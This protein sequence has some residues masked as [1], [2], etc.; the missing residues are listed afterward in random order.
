MTISVPM[1]PMERQCR[2]KKEGSG[3]EHKKGISHFRITTFHAMIF[4][5]Q[6][7]LFLCA[8]YR[9]LPCRLQPTIFGEMFVDKQDFDLC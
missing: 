1:N 8:Q 4:C 9:H 6:M 2:A 5:R 3:H 7:L